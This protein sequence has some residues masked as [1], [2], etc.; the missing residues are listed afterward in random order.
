MFT[1]CAFAV[2]I[3]FPGRKPSAMAMRRAR[4]T[5]AIQKSAYAPP[6]VPVAQPQESRRVRQATLTDLFGRHAAQQAAAAAAPDEF[7]DLS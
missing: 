7:M 3:S 2:Q 1:E 6:A 5:Q 4:A